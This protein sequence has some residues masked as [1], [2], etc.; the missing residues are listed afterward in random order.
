MNCAENCVALTLAPDGSQYVEDESLEESEESSPGAPRTAAN[1]KA[2]KA[3][4]SIGERE[5]ILER[6]C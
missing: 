4:R 5:F 2:K 3:A 6:T 1:T